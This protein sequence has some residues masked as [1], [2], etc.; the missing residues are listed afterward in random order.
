VLGKLSGRIPDLKARD[1]NLPRREGQPPC[2][3]TPCARSGTNGDPECAPYGVQRYVVRKLVM[4]RRGTRR[5]SIHEFQILP[6]HDVVLGIVGR[7]SQQPNPP[8]GKKPKDDPIHS[9]KYLPDISAA[10]V[11]DGKGGKGTVFKAGMRGT[12]TLHVHAPY[13]YANQ[14]AT[15]HY[16]RHTRRETHSGHLCQGVT[17]Q[18]IKKKKNKAQE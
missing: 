17:K 3:L 14:H 4:T 6:D 18:E 7:T 2:C 1:N 15:C 12:E 10:G 11:Y 5:N 13:R 9:T 16:T 8:C